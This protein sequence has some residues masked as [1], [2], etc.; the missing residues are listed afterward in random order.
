MA[1]FKKSEIT[2]A[3]LIRLQNQDELVLRPAFQRLN[4]WSDDA[5]SFLI[6]TIVRQWPM[7][8]FFFRRI[9]NPK[10]RLQAL[11]VVDGQQRIKS[12]LDFSEGTLRLSRIHD[13][14]GGATFEALPVSVQRMFLQY[15][16]SVEIMEDATDPEVWGL[17]ERLNT[18]TIVL[19]KQEKLNARYFGYFKQAAYAIAADEASL[20]AWRSLHLFGDPQMARMLEVEFTSDVLVALLKGI[21][22]ITAIPAV[23]KEFD[24]EF[25]RKSGTVRTFRRALAFLA[26]EL[27]E[28][29]RT[30]KFRN[31]TWAYSLLVAIA[32]AQTG[33]PDGAGPLNLQPGPEIVDRM[34]DI[35]EVVRHREWPQGLAELHG[36]FS[37]GTSHA[38]ERRIRHD[39]FI[40]MLTLPDARW[41]RRWDRLIG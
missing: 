26:S 13:Q 41:T 31:R 14:F 30:T 8:K 9:V 3:E 23:Y 28:G 6:D 29:V 37:R 40:A 18:Y 25:P 1:T 22:D 39:H 11:E 38:P 10:T 5:R 2:I 12:I 35:H 16:L 15:R 17:F 19:N 24:K 7:P 21:S 33:I 4:V 32:D 27:V 20:K 34:L 36:T